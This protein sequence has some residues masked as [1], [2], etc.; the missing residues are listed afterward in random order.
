MFL[1]FAMLFHNGT[2]GLSYVYLGLYKST[3][4]DG[5]GAALAL[6]P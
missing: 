6:L 2:K 3:G 5:V 4:L 1:N